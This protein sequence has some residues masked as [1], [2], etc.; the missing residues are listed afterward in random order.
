MERVDTVII[1]GGIAGLT[2]AEELAKKGVSVTILEKYKNW[3]GRIVTFRSDATAKVPALQYEIGAGR[4]YNDH[5]RVAALV[6]RFNLTKIP[7]TASS[8]FHG[9]PNGISQQMHAISA[10]LETLDAKAKGTHTIQ[11]LLPKELHP[12][13]EQF[14]YRA[15]VDLLRADL[16]LEAFQPAG[17]MGATGSEF[18]VLKEGLDAITDGIAAAAKAAGADLRAHH[19]VD[20]ANLRSDGLLDITG[21]HGKKDEAKPF[22]LVAKRLVI[23]TCRCSLSDFS[24]LKGAPLLKQLSTSPLIRIYAVYPPNPVTKKV[25][26][27]G[28]E[29]VVTEGR[30]RHVI[31]V[32]AD[33]GLIMIS[34]TDGKDCLY[35]RGLE[36]KALQDAI[37]AE[38]RAEFPDKEIPEPVFL[39]KHDWTMGCTYWTPGDYEV[40]A[41][42]KAAHNPVKN[43]FV[44]GES[45]SKAQAWIEGALESVERLLEIPAFKGAITP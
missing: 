22:H 13:L 32:R 11:E 3:G 27:D 33:L 37:Q 41:A 7:I 26:F 15:E 43:V 16:A 24:V 21:S 30:L 9:A 36:G 1:G 12:I 10:A 2:L 31:P 45:V 40:D 44:V 5:T 38:A 17:P 25:W 4:I 39:K 29:K 34:Y 6:K 23:A 14:P 19:H 20:D 42:L 18:Y 8:L 28:M 35:W